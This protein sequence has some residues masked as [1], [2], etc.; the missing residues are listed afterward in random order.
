M[1]HIKALKKVIN[2]ALANDYIKKD[3][4]V[5]YKITTQ[6]V[7]RQVLT[8]HEINLLTAKD[9]NIERLR[10]VRDLFL[11]Q[12]FTGL[13]FKDI[14]TLKNEHIQIDINGKKWIY[15][16]R[17]KT[18]V[19]CKIP[20]LTKAAEILDKYRSLPRLKKPEFIFPVPSNQKMNAYLKEIGTICGI[21][22]DLHSHLGRHT[23]ATTIT[24]SHGIPI[25]TISKTLG[26]TKITTTQIYAKVN[27]HKVG[28]EFD[29]LERKI[30]VTA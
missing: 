26:H 2:I 3:P 24:L 7:E 13:S 20:L 21:D 17:H 27:D 1:K 23:Y 10:I 25:E 8:M 12:C 15:K 14:E 5:N 29:E 4:F 19:L 22:K 9:I 28:V 30:N 18:G 11:F 16:N 6:K